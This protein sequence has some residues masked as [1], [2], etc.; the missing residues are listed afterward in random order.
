MDWEIKTGNCLDVLKELPD[1][2]VQCCVTSPPYWGLRD[3]GLPP[4]KWPGVEYAPMAG[5]PPVAVLT[6]EGQL[7]LEPTPEMYTAHLLAVFREVWRVLRN[8]GTLW[9]NLGDCYTSGNRDARDPGR[10]KPHSAYEDWR[11]GNRPKTP[12]GLKDKDLV[13]IPWRVA[14]ALQAD[15]WYLRSDIIW[16]KTN[17][18]PESVTDRPTKAHEYV[19]LLAKNKH[20][21]Y[22]AKAIKEPA[23]WE[24][25][26]KQ[27]TKKRNPGTVSWLPDKEKEELVKNTT[28]NKRS[29]WEIPTRP[30]PQAH[31]ATFPVQLAE[32]CILAGTS[33][34]VCPV[35]GTPWKRV[36]ERTGHVNKREPAHAYDNTSTKT[37]STGWAPVAVSTEK[38]EPACSCE[39]NDGSGKC[40]VLDPFCGAGTTGVAALRHFRRF[41]GIEMNPEYVAMA[42]RRIREDMPLFNGGECLAAD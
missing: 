37:D 27:T 26:G 25:W 41:V 2:S 30:F 24:R 5:L 14:F 39:R 21:Y 19:Y 13:G 42:E 7:G 10:N 28:K 8:D 32:T 18:M 36:I 12:T 16:E 6:W 9:L 22:D 31:F 35:C 4:A 29:V 3:Y 33:P 20:Y 1:Q 38:F 17:A 40:V 11:K 34:Y 23:A 15:G